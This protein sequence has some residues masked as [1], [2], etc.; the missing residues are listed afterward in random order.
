[1]AYICTPAPK[2]TWNSTGIV[3]FAWKNI[4]SKAGNAK[5]SIQNARALAEC[6]G[7]LIKQRNLDYVL[8]SGDFPCKT[9]KQMKDLIT[10]HFVSS[11]HEDNRKLKDLFGFSKTL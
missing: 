5:E 7:I 10:L 8:N 1:M 2:F 6:H 11:C 9:E 4:Y 3:S